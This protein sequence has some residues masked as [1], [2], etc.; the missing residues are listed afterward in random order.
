MDQE[1]LMSSALLGGGIGAAVWLLHGVSVVIGLPRLLVY[2]GLGT[3]I[4]YAI[5]FL[6]TPQEK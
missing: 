2:A 6:T 1:R 3:A 5:D 4:A